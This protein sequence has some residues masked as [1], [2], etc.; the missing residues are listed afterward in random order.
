MVRGLSQVKLEDYDDNLGVFFFGIG[1]C[2]K[3][4]FCSEGLEKIPLS[5][6]PG[7]PSSTSASPV[8]SVPLV[9]LGQNSGLPV[10]I[11]KQ[12]QEMLH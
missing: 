6:A 7:M 10:P 1:Q 12:P 4:P 2:L 9:L 3:S 5:Y 11:L 8:L